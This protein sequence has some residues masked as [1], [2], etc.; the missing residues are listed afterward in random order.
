MN[1]GIELSSNIVWDSNH[2]G[3]H[4]SRISINAEQSLDITYL[5]SKIDILDKMGCKLCYI[6][7]NG[8]NNVIIKRQLGLEPISINSRFI[9]PVRQEEI[10]TIDSRIRAITQV[11]PNLYELAYAAGHQSRYLLDPNFSQKEFER[12]YRTW[13]NNSINKQIA[14]YLLGF[15]LDE[16]L[17]GFISLKI[18]SNCLII[19]L[20]SVD[21]KVRNK[22]IGRKLIKAAL[23][24]AYQNS[25][26]YVYVTT[27]ESNKRACEF[28]S[29]MG[30]EKESSVTIYHKW[31]KK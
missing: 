2:F 18:A 25:C 7:D 30:F 22:G 19:G 28:Y 16:E 31:F 14:D 17:I 27:Q 13:V 5:L 11:E 29:K 24:I 26:N 20:L 15:Y 4:I 6:E 9:K 3:F 1:S 23:N 10:S 8:K 21:S 12:F